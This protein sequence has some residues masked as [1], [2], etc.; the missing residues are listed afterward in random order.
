M[1]KGPRPPKL[2]PVPTPS[3]DPGIPEDEPR[4]WRFT[5]E[6][7]SVIVSG[8]NVAD[9]V[10]ASNVGL[11]IHVSSASGFVGYVPKKAAEEMIGYLQHTGKRLVG[12]VLENENANLRVE[13]CAV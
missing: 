7:Q 6:E 4:C 2:P 12:L 9:P 13:L 11:R 8:L 10:F 1:G 3:D 5:P